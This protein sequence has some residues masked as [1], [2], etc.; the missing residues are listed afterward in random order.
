MQTLQQLYFKLT[1]KTRI[2]ILCF[3]YSLCILAAAVLSRSDSTLIR[4]GSLA[5]FIGL[6]AFFG[7]L[8]IWGIDSSIKR[9][10]AQLQTMAKGDL[11]Q[12]IT[13]RNNNEISWIL[14]SLI[15]LQTSMRS[16]ITA[17]QATSGQLTTAAGN[18]KLTS[19]ELEEGAEQATGQS[20]SV[21]H[22]VE[23]LSSVSSHISQNCQLMADKAAETNSASAEG[24]RTIGEMSRM[25]EEID[26]VVTETT[27]AVGSLGNNSQQIGEI[28]ATIRDIA[29]QTN[30]LAL[31][32]AI[33][34]AR[35]GEQGRGFAVVADEV[36]KL[37]ERTTMATNDIQKIIAT[38][39][40]DVANVMGSMEQSSKSAQNGVNRVKLSNQA[41]SDITSHIKVLTD[42]ISQ[43]ATA[44]EEQSATTAGVM[45][46]I[47]AIS[48]VINNVSAGTKK[49][50]QASADLARTAGELNATTAKFK[51]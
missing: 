31:N 4:Y 9:V 10:I 29:D 38:L 14:L 41:I 3:C 32:A 49:T 43:V 40:R 46:N 37:A 20:T 24:S 1:I 39:Q 51:V 42:N 44:V 7:M 17:I 15:E 50:D 12:N 5:L 35:A 23:E 6:G 22:A 34:A 11:S 33:E 28:V 13:V 26:K 25:M 2:A 47:R 30:L 36:R 45:D 18:L 8:N 48:A 19:E 16:M 27:E 21:V